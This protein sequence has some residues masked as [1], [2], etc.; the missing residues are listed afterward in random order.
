M[1]APHSPGDR[2]TPSRSPFARASANQLDRLVTR[3]NGQC[4]CS[5]FLAERKTELD[6]LRA[7]IIALRI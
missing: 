1:I 3:S 6:E 5:G 4:W 2:R 7:M